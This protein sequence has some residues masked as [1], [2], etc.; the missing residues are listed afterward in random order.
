[1]EELRVKNNL[2]VGGHVPL[3]IKTYNKVI[4]MKIV[5][6]CIRKKRMGGNNEP[7]TKQALQDE[8]TNIT[9]TVMGLHGTVIKLDPYL[10][11]YILKQKNSGQLNVCERQ[12][13]TSFG[14]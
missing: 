8:L 11:S 4:K 1:M 10:I 3:N 2:K 14:T 5:W 9:G 13:F 7:K 12:K 6:Y